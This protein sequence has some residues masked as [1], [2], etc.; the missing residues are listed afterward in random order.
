MP[1]LQSCV[2]GQTKPFGEKISKIVQ[3][4]NLNYEKTEMAFPAI[5][6]LSPRIPTISESLVW[7]PNYSF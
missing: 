3:K 1:S 2:V 7:S 5:F 4:K 6:G